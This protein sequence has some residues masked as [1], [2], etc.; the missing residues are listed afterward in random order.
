MRSHDPVYE[1]AVENSP[2]LICSGFP[3]GG[4]LLHLPQLCKTIQPGDVVHWDIC[5]RYNG[6]SIDTSRTKVVGKPTAEQQRAYDVS[7]SMLEKVLEI[8]RPGLPAV[9]L[10]NTASNIARAADYTL[11]DH[12]L[13]HGIGIDPHERPDLVREETRLEENMVLAIEPRVVIDDIYVL[14]IE[15]MVLITPN[16]GVSLTQFERTPLEL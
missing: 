9:E 6:Y 8:A 15:E 5:T 11:M 7:L 4:G 13:G 14:G 12:F 10:V 3:V 16:G 1:D 2:S